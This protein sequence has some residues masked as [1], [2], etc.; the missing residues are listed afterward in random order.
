M[1]YGRSGCLCRHL[2]NAQSPSQPPAINARS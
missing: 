1:S 2:R